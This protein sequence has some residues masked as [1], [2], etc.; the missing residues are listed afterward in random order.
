MTLENVSWKSIAQLES[1][2]LKGALFDI[3]QEASRVVQT[4]QS[5]DPSLLALVPRLADLLERRPDLDGYG[6]VFSALARS[7]GLWNYVDKEAASARDELAAEIASVPDL[8]ITL[9]REQ[10]SA[11][12]ALLAGKNLI[13]S[14]PTS[15][16]KSILIDALLLNERYA[17]VAIVLPTIAL[18]DEFRRRLIKRFGDEFDVVMHFSERPTKNR[19]IF[20]GTQER[21]INRDDLGQLDLVVVDEFYKLDPYRRDDRSVTLNAAV[22]KLLN[23]A[24]QF[25]FLG[26]NIESVS[27]TEGSRWRFEFLRTRFSTVAVDTLDL[28]GVPDKEERLHTELKADTNWPALVFVSSPDKANKLAGE[29]VERNTKLGSAKALSKWMVANYGGKWEL[30]DAVALGIGVHHGRVPRA[31]ASRFVALFNSK[32]IPVLIC[33]STLI[34]GVN[35]A[36][37]SVLIYDKT[38]ANRPY[39]FFTFSNIRGRAGRLG[40][41]HVGQVYL[42]HEPPVQEDVDVSAPLFGD[43]EDAPDEY[44][45]HIDNEDVTPDIEDRVV[46]MAARVGLD[47]QD[48]RRF[49]GLGLETLVGLRAATNQALRDRSSLQWNGRPDFEEIAAVCSVICKVAKPQSFGVG[50]DR[51][52]AMYISKL[53]QSATMKAFYIWHSESY[54]GAPQRIDNVFKFLRSAEFNIAEYFAVVE[55]FV[56]ARSG[57]ADYSLFL[58]ELPRWFRA[59]ALKILEEQG[60]PIQISERFLRGGDTVR[61]LG[62]RLK[63]LA[64]ADNDALSAVERAWIKDALP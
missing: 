58:A 9:H 23:R 17:R 37:K 59:E 28:K 15:F 26:P 4:G 21:L 14:A 39:D 48:I 2:A 8:G 51:Q 24:S 44:V 60:V 7:V 32:S 31:L 6:E 25:F 16:G 54:K 30:S 22:Y 49:S 38:I 53:R 10:V 47:A 13:L 1:T 11:L 34:E 5:D 41:H 56:K 52:M 27:T 45:V 61:T 63:A 19:V 40:Q 20:L 42:F 29:L 57:R 33:T 64:D 43:P 62:A 50:S 35:T 46:D 18:L 3:L 55:L 12:Q 36:A